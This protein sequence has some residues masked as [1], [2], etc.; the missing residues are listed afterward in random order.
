MIITAMFLAARGVPPFDS[1]NQRCYDCAAPPRRR[2]D[3]SDSCAGRCLQNPLQANNG[4]IR[5]N[6]P[7]G[8]G[9]HSILM[10]TRY[11]IRFGIVSL[12]GPF[13]L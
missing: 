5:R 10:Y 11:R 2:Q 9:C 6:V 4:N 7:Y 12:M 13:K 3:A 1:S 8:S